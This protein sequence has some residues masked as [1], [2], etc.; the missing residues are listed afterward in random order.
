M[1]NLAGIENDSIVDGPGIRMTIFFSGCK[2]HCYKCHNPQTWDFNYGIKFDDAKQEEVLQKFGEDELLDGITLSG[3][4]PFYSA[5]DVGRFVKKFKKEYPDKSVWVFT[6]FLWE[7]LIKDKDM[8]ELAKLCDVVVDGPF[9][10]EQIDYT[11]SFRGSYNQ[12]FIDVKKSLKENN[13]IE[14]KE[15]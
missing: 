3:G 1:V 10:L 9:I 14:Y 8:K 7:D 12:R 5:I 11:Q 2:H 6:G 4:D 15:E 13:I